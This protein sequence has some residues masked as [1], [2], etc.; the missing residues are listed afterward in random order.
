MK[1]SI[2]GIGPVSA[3]GNGVDS[4]RGGLSGSIRPRIERASIATASGSIELPVFKADVEGL[5]RFVNRRAMRR[6]D[7]LSRMFLLATFLALEDSGVDIE[8]KSRVGMVLGTA[9]GP[10]T[11]TFDYLDTIID[12]GDESASPTLFANSVHNAAASAVSILTKFEGPC[13]TL[14]NFD[15][16]STEVLHAASTWLEQG[17]VDF[18]LA[19]VGDVFSPVLGY[20]VCQLGAGGSGRIDPFRFDACSYA[21]AEGS[22]AFLFGNDTG[23]GKY[24]SVLDVVS[25]P[26]SATLDPSPIQGHR[27]LLLSANGNREN[28]PSYGQLELGDVK[29]AAYASVYGSLPVGFGFDVALAAVSLDLGR[30]NPPAA[31]TVPN[32][33]D[34]LTEA[35]P[36]RDDDRIGCLECT[37][38]RIGFASVG[39]ARGRVAR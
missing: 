21:P 22:V 32:G 23:A 38:S 37:T 2:L 19:G 17:T 33:F 39:R 26:A 18:V 27:A 29:V 4:L 15:L 31:G 20:A 34:L 9:Y 8:D 30:L 7:K 14:T 24:G 5:E 3:L 16:V 28:G 13:L 10:L 12:G 11:T 36:L 6:L 35:V 25:A 1:L